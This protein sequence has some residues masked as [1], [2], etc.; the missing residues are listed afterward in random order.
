MFNLIVG[1]DVMKSCDISIHRY[2]LLSILTVLMLSACTGADNNS[3]GSGG[4]TSNSP[5]A[6]NACLTDANVQMWVDTVNNSNAAQ[7]AQLY[8]KWW[9]AAGGTEPDGD[10]PMW[11]ERLQPN[12]NTR[13]GSDTW[14][15]KECHGWDYKGADGVYGSTS[16]D[17]YT[18]FPGILSATSKSQLEVFCAIHSGTS[19]AQNHNFSE[20]I[21]NNQIANL[22]RFITVSQDELPSEATPKGMTDIS[23]LFN[24]GISSGDATNGN[25][26][27]NMASIGCSTSN[28]HGADGTVQHE[29]LGTLA[30]DNP[31]ETIHKIRFGH[32]G[33]NLM[34]AFSANGSN[35]LT[36]NQSNDVIAYA[37]QSLPNPGSGTTPPAPSGIA[38]TVRGGLLYDNWI[39]ETGTT[40]AIVN[41]DNPLWSEQNSNMR[42]GPDTWR[43][44]ECHGWDY[45][46]ADGIYGNTNSDHY[47]G[48]SGIWD[49]R[50]D[51]VQ[52]LITFLTDGFEL[53]ILGGTTN[54]HNF[55]G[56]LSAADI[57]A[58]AN[59]VLY[60][61]GF[62]IN[63]YIKPS[64]VILE[65]DYLR[66]EELY[67]AKPF[68]FANGNCEL[69]HELDGKGIEP[70]IVGYVANDNPWETLHKIRFGQP[71]S[72]MPSLEEAG[73]NAQDATDIVFYAKTLPIQ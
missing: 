72:R 21:P 73:F 36:L 66:G 52:D 32:P 16:S 44:K 19:E 67:L 9:V 20:Q 64:G 71:N 33:A 4:N 60:V 59:F 56:L 35:S 63:A 2:I 50:Y 12:I 42:T 62:D 54:V 27:Y 65:G 34:P 1:H 51:N 11:S 17:H 29:P 46:G 25:S 49:T 69:C 43:C 39:S 28:C 57:N 70:I 14:R 61:R 31:W 3:G 47:T 15:C 24:N 58:L 53:P 18:G 48:F 13:S 10:H 5:N 6:N 41:D 23:T 45:K 26:I 55:G 40:S 22:T 38:I 37:Q 68:G 8:D 7:G 30:T